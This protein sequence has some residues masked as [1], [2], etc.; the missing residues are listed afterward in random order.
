V[1]QKLSQKLVMLASEHLQFSE[2]EFLHF[3]HTG[4]PY[5]RTAT[6]NF[7]YENHVL[8]VVPRAEA[9]NI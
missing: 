8:V 1:P 6:R 4:H 2:R 5:I 7:T 9:E 3:V